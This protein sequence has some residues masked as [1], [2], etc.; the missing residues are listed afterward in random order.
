VKCV[1][2]EV[3]IHLCCFF[4]FYLGGLGSNIKV[5]NCSVV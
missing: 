2:A 4:G 3:R 5:N 1:A